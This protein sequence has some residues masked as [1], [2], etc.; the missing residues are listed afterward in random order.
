[1]RPFKERSDCIIN[2]YNEFVVNVIFIFLLCNNFIDAENEYIY[3]IGWG[4]VGCICLSL[5]MTWVVMVPTVLSVFYT[6]IRDCFFP[7]E[8]NIEHVAQNN[9]S[10][11]VY[12]ENFKNNGNPCKTAKSHFSSDMRIFPENHNTLTELNENNSEA[13]IQKDFASD[14]NIA[15]HMNEENKTQ[16]VKNENLYNDSQP[17]EMNMASFEKNVFIDYSNKSKFNANN[18][19]TTELRKQN[20]DF[21]QSNEIIDDTVVFEEY[22]QRKHEN[23]LFMN[24]EQSRN[25]IFVESPLDARKPVGLIDGKMFIK[26]KKKVKSKKKKA[27]KG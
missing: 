12:P 22:T 8:E 18:I 11:K 20:T 16:D 5:L 7:T 10:H 1:M 26:V 23:S 3:M 6:S 9:E 4:M 13:K 27:L 2:I 15:I 21:N 14:N 19:D 25:N 24:I 17:F